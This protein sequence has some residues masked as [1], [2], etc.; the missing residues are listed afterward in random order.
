[1]QVNETSGSITNSNYTIEATG[2]SPITGSPVTTT[3]IAGCPAINLSPGT[4]A[5]GSIGAFYSETISASG[6]SGSYAFSVTGGD[7][8]PG[9]SLSSGGI[10]SG[11]P[12]SGGSYSFVVRAVDSNECS[13]SRSYTIS[14]AG[15]CS[16]LSVSPSVLFEGFVGVPYNRTISGNGGTPPYSLSLTSGSLPPGLTLSG[17][18]LSGTPTAA[19]TFTFRITARDA[20]DCTAF[21]NYTLTVACPP[22]ALS[23]AVLVGASQGVAYS[24]T[25]TVLGGAPR[26]YTFSV[27][28]GL[29]AGLTLS[30]AGVLSGVPAQSGSFAFT[31]T[32]TDANG[33]A[34]S[35]TY[36]L[37]V[38]S[39]LAIIPTALLPATVGVPFG[40]IFAASGG[41]PPYAFSVTGGALPPGLTLSPAGVLTGTPSVAGTFSFTLT[42]TD[43]NGCTGSVTYTLVPCSGLALSPAALPEGARGI[44]YSQ[45]LTASGGT[46]PYTFGPSGSLPPGLTLSGEVLSGT[47]TQSGTFT[48]MVFAFDVNGCSGNRTYAIRVT[49]A[50]PT[51]TSLRL[52]PGAA[53]GFTLSVAGTGFVAGGTIFVNGVAYPATFVSP[54]LVTVA[55][56]ASAIPQDGSITVTVTNPGPT[57]ATSN[58][59]SLTFCT[60]P[61]APVNPTIRPLGNPTGPLTATD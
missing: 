54:T 31:V 57:G 34:V 38:C 53:G 44:A 42:A 45:R 5:G 24:Q 7:L 15:G 10:L 1:M 56:P 20:S 8:P 2:I 39:A 41:T 27:T 32:A 33:C 52:S 36:T 17:G 11:M 23:P 43:A 40:Q 37:A 19:G 22:V 18:S 6:G 50:P 51:I 60:A 3:V 55:L 21:R 58:P 47:P 49:D 9:L 61:G 14:I 16:T 25:F 28:P 26:P 35:Q 4:L 12:T 13:G 46:A 59:A 29:P 48:F 30:S